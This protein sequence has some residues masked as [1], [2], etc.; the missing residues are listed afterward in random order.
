MSS[1]RLAFALLLTCAG[2]AI[3]QDQPSTAIVPTPRPGGPMRRHE[4]LVE[5]ARQGEVDLLFLGDTSI[6]GWMGATATWSRHYAS[7]KAANF[8]IGGDQ[9]QNL[10]WRLDHGGLEGI[11]PRVVV[12]Q[13]GGGNIGR[14]TEFEVAEGVKAVVD[15]LKI[16]LPESKILLLGIFPRG[17]KRDKTEPDTGIDPRVARINAR[18]AAF[19]DRKNVKYLDIGVHFLDD[20]GQVNRDVMP[21]HVNLSLKGYQIWADAIEPTLWAWMEEKP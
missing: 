2:L 21:D 13:I 18:L 5:R 11:K 4:A 15:K 10:L 8:G 1:A 16:K 17:L 6:A 12:L 14:N 19:D 7:R 3:G 20:A 9:T